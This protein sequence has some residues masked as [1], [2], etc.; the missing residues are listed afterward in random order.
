[1][2][3]GLGFAGAV[4]EDKVPGFAPANFEL[5]LCNVTYGLGGGGGE[6][7]GIPDGP[8]LG[9]LLRFAG[10]KYVGEPPR[11]A[12]AKAVGELPRDAGLRDGGGLPSFAGDIDGTKLSVLP[13]PKDKALDAKVDGEVLRFAGPMYVG[14]LPS[15]AGDIDGN[16][17][18]G[19]P[20]AKGKVPGAKGKEAI[21]ISPGLRAANAPSNNP[22]I[23]A[24]TCTRKDVV[25]RF[26]FESMT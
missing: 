3:V 10:A 24:G 12:G 16:E 20:P 4:C 5:S 13:S 17:V 18:Q 22:G 23:V 14:G 7:E 19:L 25:M 11:F 6:K 21:P 26:P 15:F 1:M 9:E 8:S 2:F